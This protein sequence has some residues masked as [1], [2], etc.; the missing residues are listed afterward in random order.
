MRRRVGECTWH[1]HVFFLVLECLGVVCSRGNGPDTR[2]LFCIR[3]QAA[4]HAFLA[5]DSCPCGMSRIGVGWLDAFQATSRRVA[6]SC[7]AISC[8]SC[9]SFLLP[10][11]RIPDRACG[12]ARLPTTTCYSP[13]SP[14]PPFVSIVSP[15]VPRASKMDNCHPHIAGSGSCLLLWRQVDHLR[16]H[17]S[18]ATH[19]C[20]R[21]PRHACPTVLRVLRALRM[22]RRSPWPSAVPQWATLGQLGKRAK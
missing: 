3:Y 9:I 12:R 14:G 18:E 1:I 10:R 19:F 22:R 20:N 7:T 4:I 11:P 6:A 15:H 16:L 5:G 21:Q 13:A 8:L 2:E 17:F